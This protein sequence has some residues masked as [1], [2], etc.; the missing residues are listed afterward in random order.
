MKEWKKLGVG[1]QIRD[2]D[3]VETDEDLAAADGE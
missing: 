1:L 2:L 3:V